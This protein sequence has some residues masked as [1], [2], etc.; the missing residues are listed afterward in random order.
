MYQ[1][2]WEEFLKYLLSIVEEKHNVEKQVFNAGETGL[3]YK[4]IGKWTN[5]MPVLVLLGAMARYSLI[6][7]AWQ[8][9]RI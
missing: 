4:G 9:Y 7:C 3:F 6:Q 2:S 8:L 1:E 5:E